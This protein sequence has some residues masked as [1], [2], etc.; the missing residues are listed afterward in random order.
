MENLVQSIIKQAQSL[1][2]M[3]TNRVKFIPRAPWLERYVIHQTPKNQRRLVKVKSLPTEQK[4]KFMDQTIINRKK[5]KKLHDKDFDSQYLFKTRS[6]INEPELDDD[7]W[8]EEHTAYTNKNSLVIGYINND[9]YINDT[10]IPIVKS[11]INDNTIIISDN[12][13][14]LSYFT[15]FTT[16]ELDNSN[17]IFYDDNKIM[18]KSRVMKKLR[19]K[20]KSKNMVNT[21]MWLY[22]LTLGLNL[23]Q[24]TGTQEIIDL[25]KIDESVF[26]KNNYFSL[27]ANEYIKLRQKNMIDVIKNEENNNKHIIMITDAY[28]VY[29]IKPLIEAI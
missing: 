8:L 24:P 22:S 4:Q 21:V 10:L 23:E 1:K 20:F 17:T 29:A 5:L 26:E 9:E 16:K 25:Y 13:N 28:N 12:K 14:I 7:N 15:N 2:P 11:N 3:E 19:L 6:L 18:Q 27:V